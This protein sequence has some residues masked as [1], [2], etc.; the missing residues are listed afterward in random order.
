MHPV[1]IRLHFLR[2]RKHHDL[3]HLLCWHFPQLRSLYSLSPHLR[4][5]HILNNVSDMRLRLHPKQQP[6]RGALSLPLR[7]LRL[8]QQLSDLFRGL[9]SF[10]NQLSTRCYLF[11]NIFVHGLSPELRHHRWNLCPMH[12]RKLHTVHC[13]CHLNL[14]ALRRHSLR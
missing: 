6:L 11:L 7:H 3:S 10:R 14:R 12:G 8:F 4:H 5:L 2:P 1:F 9:Q 13:S